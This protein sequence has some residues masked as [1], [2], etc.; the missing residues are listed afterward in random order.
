MTS[1]LRRVERL[2]NM[3]P[4]REEELE[5]Q[6]QAAYERARCAVG[7]GTP[8][9]EDLMIWSEPILEDLH[10]QMLLVASRFQWRRGVGN[11]QPI[12]GIQHAAAQI[13]SYYPDETPPPH[14][15]ESL[16]EAATGDQCSHWRI[17]NLDLLILGADRGMALRQRLQDHPE[18]C[19]DYFVRLTPA[20]EAK[21]TADRQKHKDLIDAGTADRIDFYI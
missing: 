12:D 10:H 19:C 4:T 14:L 21:R 16:L 17:A 20:E 3:L 7:A 8:T 9:I 6:K 2:I 11:N 15:L 13:V 5:N 1:R 18:D